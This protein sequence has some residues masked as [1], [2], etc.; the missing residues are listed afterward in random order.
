MGKAEYIRVVG[1]W[2]GVPDP[3][4]ARGKRYGWDLLLSLICWGMASGQKSVAGIGDWVKLHEAELRATLGVG[5]RRL[6]STATLRRALGSLDPE[7]LEQVSRKLAVRATAGE[8]AHSGLVGQAIDGKAVRGAGRH[9]QPLCLVARVAHETGRVL[10]QVAVSL[11]SNEITAVP[12]LLARS[13]DTQVVIT[14]DALLTQREIAV[15][16]LASGSNYLMVAKDNQ[17]RLSTTIASHFL[18]R[19]AGL[20][21]ERFETVDK[22]HGRLERRIL[23]VAQAPQAWIDWPGAKQ[24]LRRT[25]LRTHLRSGKTTCSVC[26][27]LT[28]LSRTLAG[29]ADL[30]RLWRGH[31]TI[32]NRVH[33]IRDVSMGEDACQV[34]SGKAPRSLAIVRNLLLNALRN[35]P[36]PSIPA[37]HRALA[38][39][40]VTA[41][42]FL[43]DYLAPPPLPP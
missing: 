10:D 17:P 42:A 22:G 15:Q 16:I 18:D 28:S 27:G 39:N 29:P 21:V 13:G 31:W 41:F 23:E 19:P 2:E 34:R 36:W 35:G 9:G 6:P 25:C 4:R 14:M 24:I 32:E 20:V 33:F 26:Y 7:A 12:V 40:L 30:E 5:Q 43:A 8:Q 1:W 11:K 37:A 38:S 3:R